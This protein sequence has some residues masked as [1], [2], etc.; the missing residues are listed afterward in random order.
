[1]MEAHRREIELFWSWFARNRSRLEA[2]D[3]AVI[4][5]LQDQVDALGG[6][7]W[8]LG[9]DGTTTFSLTISPDGDPGLLAGSRRIIALAPKTEGWVFYPARQP[10]ESPTFLTVSEEG[11]DFEID[12]RD[13]E[14]VIYRFPDQYTELVLRI[15][16]PLDSIP[17]SV[18][19]ASAAT[20]VDALLG[21]E[22]R[23]ATI[24]AI[25]I[26]REW[27]PTEAD[28]A[29]NISTLPF[30]VERLRTLTTG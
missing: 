24:D 14:F 12:A 9:P 29:A 27:R 8:E 17:E 13:W 7:A 20:V 1:M 5:E 10:R 21:E 19:H 25:D 26:V 4:A 2:P 3:D 22:T 28:K 16:L 6:F 30:A 18:A 11:L 15:G 23:L